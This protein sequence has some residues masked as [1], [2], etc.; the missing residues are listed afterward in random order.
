MNGIL[1]FAE[2]LKNPKLPE[3]KQQEFIKIIEKSGQRML[4]IISDIVNISKIETGQI[5][6]DIKETN[7]NDI[8]KHL[9]NFFGPDA[10]KK[11]LKLDFK[12]G[13]SDD[14]CKIETDEV[15]LTQ[16]LSNLLNN[17]LKFTKAGTIEF[18]YKLKGKVL[19]FYIRDTG[20][21]IG[22]ENLDI[23]FERFRQADMSVTRNFEGAGLGLS[24]SKAYVEKLNGKIWVKS[25]LDKGSTFFFSI[26]YNPKVIVNVETPQEAGLEDNLSGI[27]ILIAEDDRFCMEL[28]KEVLE[29]EKAILFLANDGKEAL[30]MVKSVPEIQLVL[31]DLKMPVMNG[32]ESTKLIK[33]LKPGLP[34]IAQSA[35]A[36]SND[37][38]KAKMAGCDD[39]IGK[40]LKRELLLSKIHKYISKK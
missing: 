16:V 4:N 25:E 27:H 33:K 28:L 1:G 20:I 29:E 40:P 14:L 17:A 30:D 8:L 3:V 32:F 7:V 24:I 2:L 12:T 18:G 6:L 9:H 19:E 22:P 39:F 10:E 26:P 21:G 13:L 11:N 36:F 23:I 34:V 15:K 31:M 5:E 35:Y 38:D 37:Q